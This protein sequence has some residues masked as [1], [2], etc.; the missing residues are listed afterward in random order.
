[1]SKISNLGFLKRIKQDLQHFLLIILICY[2]AQRIEL[3]IF[4]PTSFVSVSHISPVGH[5][6]AQPP[7]LPPLK[8]ARGPRPLTAQQRQGSLGKALC[9][10]CQRKKRQCEY[11]TGTDI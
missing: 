11:S 7:P 9:R 5:S 8:S 3:T 1:M 10:H 4:Y 2:E 6:S